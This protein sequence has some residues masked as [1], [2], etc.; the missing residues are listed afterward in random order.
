[1]K[2]LSPSKFRNYAQSIAKTIIAI[3]FFLI[4]FFVMNIYLINGG[5]L[6][7]DGLFLLIM[8]GM[9]FF[10]ANTSMF[11]AIYAVFCRIYI[12]KD[13]LRDMEIVEHSDVDSGSTYNYYLFFDEIFGKY[14]KKIEVSKEEYGEAEIGKSY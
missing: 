1:M 14:R 12:Y 6:Q 9:V 8:F 5:G 10:L 11:S 7:S 4:A 13:V 3:V 2:S